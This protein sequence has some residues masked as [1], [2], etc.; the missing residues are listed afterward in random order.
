MDV[1]KK[2]HKKK[3]NV[4]EWNNNNN[5]KKKT[6][7]LQSLLCVLFFNGKCA[8]GTFDA[9]TFMTWEHTQISLYCVAHFLFFSL[10]FHSFFS[11]VAHDDA[12]IKK[13][14]AIIFPIREK[15]P[16][17]KRVYV[18][19]RSI[20]RETVSL[21]LAVKSTRPKSALPILYI[22]GALLFI[23]IVEKKGPTAVYKL[24]IC[25]EMYNNISTRC[26]AI[27]CQEIKRVDQRVRLYL[28]RLNMFRRSHYSLTPIT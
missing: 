21:S 19:H 7:R 17:I 10:S 22:H 6:V 14:K 4:Q 3:K 20:E 18:A 9:G 23:A 12:S 26:W 15:K 24:R 5:N 2:P 11:L 28:T 13:W 27:V 25:T 8:V 16:R 1:F